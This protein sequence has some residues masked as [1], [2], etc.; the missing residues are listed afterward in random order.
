MG[1]V[2]FFVS[3][4]FKI[5]SGFLQRANSSHPLHMHTA[6]REHIINSSENN[7]QLQIKLS[8]KELLL[9]AAPCTCLNRCKQVRPM[10][11][12]VPRYSCV[13][14]YSV[15]YFKCRRLN[16]LKPAHESRRLATE[17]RSALLIQSYCALCR[18]KTRTSAESLNRCLSQQRSPASPQ[19]SF[20]WRLI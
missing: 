13:L 18:P 16:V 1:D 3:T 9:P 19:G 5:I 10:C 6:A 8:Q 14:I 7:L 12:L 20:K 11:I 4:A 2:L 15:A 17:R